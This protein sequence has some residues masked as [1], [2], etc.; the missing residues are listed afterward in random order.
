MVTINI[1]SIFLIIYSACVFRVCPRFKYDTQKQFNEVYNNAT[2]LGASSEIH[3]SHDLQRLREAA[4]AEMDEN[5]HECQNVAG[6]PVVYGQIVQLQHVKSGHFVTISVK[7]MANLE[8]DCLK[9]VLEPDGTEGS[10]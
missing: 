2:L 7:E 1:L 8:K 10:W 3:A 5:I 9:V 4:L 6:Q